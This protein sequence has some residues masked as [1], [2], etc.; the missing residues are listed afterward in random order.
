MLARMEPWAIIIGLKPLLCGGSPVIL[1]LAD[2]MHINFEMGEENN[3]D[4]DILL[5]GAF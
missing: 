5:Y 4:L 1:F 2:K 3:C